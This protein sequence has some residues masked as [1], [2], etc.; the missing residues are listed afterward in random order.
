[1]KPFFKNI[2][3]VLARQIHVSKNISKFEHILKE[4]LNFS[5][6]YFYNVKPSGVTLIIQRDF[7]WI[8]LSTENLIKKTKPKIA[9]IQHDY[10]KCDES[11]S[12]FMSESIGFYRKWYSIEEQKGV[13]NHLAPG[14][15]VLSCWR[16]GVCINPCIYFD[17]G[18]VVRT[19]KV[20]IW[21]EG[22]IWFNAQSPKANQSA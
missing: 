10:W 19:I 13:G 22:Q 17:R 20:G 21:R 2:K 6:Y 4:F 14:L 11:S 18:K 15:G 5:K 8:L 16:I 12:K 3:I 9:W 7:I 1:M